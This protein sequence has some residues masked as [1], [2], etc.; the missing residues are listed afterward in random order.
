MAT[1]T[2]KH[3]GNHTHQHGPA[4]R[5]HSIGVAVETAFT[6]TLRNEHDD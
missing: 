2:E 3:H 5:A 6:L 4:E 1:C